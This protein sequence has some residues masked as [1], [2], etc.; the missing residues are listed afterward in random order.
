MGTRRE[1]SY[2]SVLLLCTLL[3]FNCFVT[4]CLVLTIVILCTYFLLW[5]T[6]F[7]SLK[8]VPEGDRVLV[9]FI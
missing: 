7:S 1:V 3:I 9:F 5:G 6:E 2:M 8:R 4:Y